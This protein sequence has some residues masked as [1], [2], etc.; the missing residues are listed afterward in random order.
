MQALGLSFLFVV[1][2]AA[3]FWF[4]ASFVPGQRQAAIGTWRRDLSI[5]ADTRRDLL[6]RRISEE[7]AGASFVATFPSVRALASSV[8]GAGSLEA[9]GAHVEGILSNFRDVYR[10]RSISI[11]DAGG[12]VLASSDGPAPGADAI[13]LA[14]EAAH[15]GKPKIDLVREPDGFIGFAVAAPVRESLQTAESG[16]AVLV[17]GPAEE[18]VFDLLRE[19][20]PSATGEA[21]LV[22]KEGDAAVHLSPLRFR[23]DP[24][25]TLHHQ[26]RAPAHT[27][28]E[29]LEGDDAFGSFVDYRGMRVFSARRKLAR[30]PWSLVIKVDEDEALAPFRRDVLRRGLMWGGLLLALSAAAF[31]LWRALVASHEVTLARSEARF[32]ALV[33]QATDAIFLIASDG[34]ILQANRAAEKIYGKARDELLSMHATDVR[35]SGTRD[36]L[37]HDMDTAAARGSLLVETR[38]VRADGS[39]FPVEVNMGLVKAGDE[40]LFL[41]IVR[42]TT[43]RK[44]AEERIRALN[45]LLKTISEVDLLLIKVADEESLLGEVCRVLVDSGGYLLAWIGRADPETMRAVP[46]ARAGADAHLLDTIVVR[47]DDSPEGH[48]PFGTAIR[49][50]RHVVV[51]DAGTD[52]STSPWLAFRSR[53]GIRS[54]AVLP[55]RRGGAVTAALVA[56]AVVPS[57]IDEEEIALLDGL[58]ADI[59]FALDVLDDRERARRS[60][61]ELRK[62]S[63][64]VEQTPATILMTD[65]EGR[66]EYA[67]PRFAEVTGYTLE[68]VRGQNP[69]ILKSDRTPPE[70]IRQLW[71]TIT[72]GRVWSG[73]LCNRRKDGTLFWEQSSISP[74]RDD[75][76][77]ITHYVAVGEDI[78]ARKSAEAELEKTRQQLAQAQR[79]EAVG[80]LAGGVAHD[81]N[82]LLTV[83]QGY[84]ELVRDSLSGDPRRESMEELLKAAGRAA[85]LTRQLLAFSRKQ[86]LE[87]KIVRLDAIV[88]ETGG[89]LER[90]IGENIALSLA[91]PETFATVKADPGQLEQVVLNLAVNARDAMPKG[92]RLTVSVGNLTTATLLEGFPD[93]LPAGRWVLL[94]MEDTGCGMDAETLSHAFEPFFTTKE[95]GKGTGLGLSTVYGIVRQSDGF[96]QVTSVPGKGTTFQVY[97]PRSADETTSGIRPSVR[98]RQGTET[99]LVVEDEPAVRNL[100]RAVLERK[101]YVVLVA[102]DGAAALDLVDKHAGVVHVLLTDVVM[103]GM[104]GHDLAALVRTRRPSIRVI[105]MSG[106]TA[107][108][109]TDLGMEGGPVFLSK[110]FTEQTLTAKLSEA[111]DWPQG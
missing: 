73:E 50:G 110:P 106:Y 90:L 44:A 38:H 54:M 58:A 87:M 43:E 33:E 98:S 93:E 40:T 76:G 25:L 102:Q 99:V 103:P 23:S 67:N 94:T 17:V 29:V 81:F 11:H 8:R 4:F 100:V 85:S 104:S 79:M 6:D 14:R 2:A 66:V 82:N 95:R 70:V 108:V 16:G 21:L 92:G 5:L 59:S 71:E 91:F 7:S 22:R 111:L 48:G 45:R 12:A 55:L 41:S 20:F 69:R 18:K 62:L 31:G 75:K 80:R 63:R 9:P 65:L 27:A 47:W 37:R 36:A 42:D 64:A 60:E 77:T 86:V 46:V 15:S 52:P 61:Q 26:M 28:R 19:P 10:E 34:R 56:Y 83:I 1:F 96:V 57:F 88:R 74:I 39:E 35:A 53:L 30:A 49:T 3:V 13:A 32:G 101:G 107:D 68:E 72:A 84:G 78:T 105:F 109:P 97:L 51:Q 24:P 89:M